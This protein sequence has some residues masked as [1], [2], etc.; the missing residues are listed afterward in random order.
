MESS[1]TDFYTFST[2]KGLAEQCEGS[3]NIITRCRTIGILQS[4]HGKFYLVELDIETR[5]TS[6]EIQLSFVYLKTTLPSTVIPLPVQ[7]FGFLQWKNRP[8]IYVNLLQVLK[9]PTAL[10][11]SKALSKI[12]NNYIAACG[13]DKEEFNLTEWTEE[14]IPSCYE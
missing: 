11:M 1:C 12:A 13:N 5:K 10:R 2:L 14:D 6:P 7:V 9:A 8:V 4:I 3:Q